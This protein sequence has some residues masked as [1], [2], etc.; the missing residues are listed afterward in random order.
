MSNTTSC[1]SSDPMKKNLRE[2]K[3]GEG[4]GKMEET[5]EGEGEGPLSSGHLCSFRLQENDSPDGPAMPR[6]PSL[7][8][9]SLKN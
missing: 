3:R 8:S 6:S 2:R 9:V 4:G 5:K 7:A 1:C